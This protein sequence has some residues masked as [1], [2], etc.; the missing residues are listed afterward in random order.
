MW[1]R[2]SGKINMRFWSKIFR[3]KYEIVVAICDE[4]LIE[5][6][7]KSKK[8]EVKIS[9][10]FY[11]ERLIDENEAVRIMNIATIGNLFGKNIVKL[12]EKYGFI[13]K[14]NVIFIKRIPHAQ[15]VKIVET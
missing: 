1:S 6:R 14:E 3:T 13:S 9:K 2:V 11:G 7:L 15:F 5:K 8:F 12:A 4:E 10:N